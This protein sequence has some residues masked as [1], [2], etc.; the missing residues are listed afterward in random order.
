MLGNGNVVLSASGGRQPQMAS[1]LAG[2]LVAK[3]SQGTG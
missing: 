3:L 1:G 2:D